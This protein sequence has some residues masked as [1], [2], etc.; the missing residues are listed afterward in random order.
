MKI[1][2]VNIR[3]ANDSENPNLLCHAS[4]TLDDCLVI[5]DLKVIMGKNRRFVS[6]PQ[7]RMTDRCHDCN[8]ANPL[9]SYYCHACGFKL[10]NRQGHINIQGISLEL[11]H[12]LT[13]ECRE[14]IEE[15]VIWHFDNEIE[16]VRQ[17]GHP[18]KEKAT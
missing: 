12:P 5:H 11:L 14:A 7:R 8:A 16:Q 13:R 2:R 10:L 6:M 17:H 15:E 18:L 4:I 3:L 1:T 9:S